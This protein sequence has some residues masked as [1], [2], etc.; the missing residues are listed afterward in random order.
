VT[1]RSIQFWT[2]AT[3]FILAPFFFGSVD[4]FWVVAWTV[5]LSL[6][7]L[8]GLGLPMGSGQSRIL[9][10]FLILCG[11]YALVAI[12]Q[13]IPN[14]IPQLND[15]IW[16]QAGRLIDRD[17]V[18]R[19]SSRAE[20]PALAIGNFLLVAFSFVNGFYVGT[21]RRSSD[22]LVR[23]ARYS[24]L[25]YA[26]YGIAALVVTPDMILWAPKLA[27]RGS[28][29][30]TFVNHNTAAT[31]VGVGFILWSCFSFYSLQ[32]LHFSSIRLLLTLR[33]NEHLAFKIVARSSA[34]LVC[35]F[36]LLLTGSRGGLI[37]SCLGLL[38]AIILMI[39]NRQ[40]P[41]FWLVLISGVG[42]LAVIVVLLSQMGRIGSQ[43]AFDDARWRVYQLCIEAIRQR[44]LLGAGLGTFAELFPSLR[45]TDFRSWGVWEVAHSTILEIAVEMGIPVA[46]M[47]ITAA[48]ASLFILARAAIRSQGRNQRVLAAITGIAVLTYLHSTIDFSLQIPGYLIVFGIL[49]GCGLA[50]ATASQVPV[51]RDESYSGV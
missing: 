25:L 49:M 36:A 13:V 28:L 8:C 43:G 18:P 27:Y 16:G 42:A 19:I 31:F 40:K 30:S 34:A 14:A 47:V 15:P 35:F 7:A 33:S 12:I 4:L 45:D 37:C 23:F 10:G 20:I 26:I 51:A 17:L 29:T 48:L 3:V 1:F 44:P 24:I 9:L 39:V 5:L 50:K 21:S 22:R 2:T 6:G 41:R 11:V 46:L 38:A 32:S